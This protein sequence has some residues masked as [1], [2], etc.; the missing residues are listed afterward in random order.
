WRLRWHA[1]RRTGLADRCQPGP[2]RNHAG[3]EVRS[4]GGATR[5]GIVIGEPHPLRG[6][7]VQIW[8]A[9]GHDSAVITTEVEP[10]YVVGHNGDDVGFLGLRQRVRDGERGEGDRQRASPEAPRPATE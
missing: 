9:A 7:P 3:D 10:T 1:N 5:L 6:E 2:D 8:R 4:A